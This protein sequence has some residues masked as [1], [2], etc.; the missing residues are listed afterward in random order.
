[1]ESQIMVDASKDVKSRA[2]RLYILEELKILAYLLCG[3]DALHR[4][5]RER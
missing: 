4:D 1:M 2:L 5:V 3:F